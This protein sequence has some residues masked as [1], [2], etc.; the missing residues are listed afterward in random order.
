MLGIEMN[1][2]KD[3]A[4]RVRRES[5]NE[6]WVSVFD[7][8]CAGTKD[9][10]V[11]LAYPRTDFNGAMMEFLIGCLAVVMAPKD[12]DEWETWR[13]SAPPRALLEER[14]KPIIPHFECDAETGPRA[15]QDLDSLEDVGET[16]IAQLLIDAPGEQ[17]LK[18]SADHF[19]K[20]GGVTALSPEMA[21][22][23]LITLQTYAPSGG[24]GHRTSLRGGGPLTMLVEPPHRDDGT[25]TLWDRLWANVPN[26]NGSPPKEA[27]YPLIFPWLART[28][29]SESNRTTSP[30][31]GEAH[32]L[33]A[34]FGMPRRVRLGFSDSG[35]QTCDLGGPSSPRVVRAFRMK[36]YGVNYS[37][38][39]S[40]PLSA[41]RKSAKKGSFP[42]HPSPGQLGYRNWLGLWG[43]DRQEGAKDKTEPARAVMIAAQRFGSGGNIRDL[44]VH[45]FGYQMDNMKPLR[46]VDQTI[47]LILD[48]RL[49]QTDVAKDAAQLIAGAEEAGQ[50][51][52][53]AVKIA[54]HGVREG[55]PGMPGALHYKSPDQLSKDAYADIPVAFERA[56]EPAFEACLKRLAVA[57]DVDAR[58]DVKET[59]FE[60]LRNAAAGL[61]DTRIDTNNQPT[62]A[63]RRIAAARK[64]L[65]DALYGAKKGVRKSLSLPARE[66]TEEAE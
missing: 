5:G 49:R 59:W 47:P 25:T 35:G 44:R 46:F 37:Q 51:L 42:L 33:Q 1:L 28:R 24:K 53:R 15:F 27:D 48:E 55:K 20:R 41:Y 39:W 43:M 12:E 45:A 61:F 13:S 4:I 31:G 8:V 58:R 11:S 65:M 21:M 57:G 56:T 16:P 54:L 52:R 64:G 17:A 3:K 23:A 9:S 63:L 29:T 22:A 19:V 50:A 32:P 62:Q 66:R 18:Q 7:S 14:F 6:E 2:L 34:F 30:A 10:I 38:S 26:R 36:S 40:H 60:Q